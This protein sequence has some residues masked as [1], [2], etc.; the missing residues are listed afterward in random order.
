MALFVSFLYIIDFFLMGTKIIY[1]IPP[2]CAKRL[3]WLVGI[4]KFMRPY[5]HNH[6]REY[7]CEWTIQLNICL[8]YW[9]FQQHQHCKNVLHNIRSLAWALIIVG[10]QA[11]PQRAHALR[12]V[13][14][15][16]LVGSLWL[17]VSLPNKCETLNSHSRAMTRFGIK[18]C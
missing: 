6:S 14:R 17:L 9:Y 7:Q 4:G 2:L 18:S 15:Y 10:P 3:R 12:L 1:H 8:L 16:H 13:Q 5:L 11:T